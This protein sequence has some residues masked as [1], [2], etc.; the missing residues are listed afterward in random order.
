MR[1]RYSLS[2]QWPENSG[3]N[4][5]FSGPGFRSGVST[6]KTL[7]CH[8]RLMHCAPPSALLVGAHKLFYCHILLCVIPHNNKR[9]TTTVSCC[10][11][12]RQRR[13]CSSRVSV[14]VCP[15]HFASC[16][17]TAQYCYHP[18]CIQIHGISSDVKLVFEQL[19]AK[20]K[21]CV[22]KTRGFPGFL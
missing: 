1:R 20:R 2:K 9:R 21:L 8:E 11:S 17:F 18:A 15:L 13:Y 14:W 22:T 6:L 16:T 3:L 19:K 4:F 7:H 5:R 12:A 10:L